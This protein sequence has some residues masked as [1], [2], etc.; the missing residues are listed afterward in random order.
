M[1]RLVAILTLLLALLGSCDQMITQH[2]AA[3]NSPDAQTVQPDPNA[4]AWQDTA[5]VPPVLSL[6]LL[7]RGQQRF[8]IFCTPCHS[9]LGDGNGMVVQR[10]FPHPPSFDSDHLRHAPTQ[11]F[12]DVMTQGYGDMYSFA[13]RLSPT[14]RWAIAAYIRALQLS[15]HATVA[16]LPDAQRGALP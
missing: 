9:E 4:V 8:G 2:K 13:G 12:F 15:Q 11:H 10:G 14:D 3:L 16:S 6:A 1:K 5:V 7:Q